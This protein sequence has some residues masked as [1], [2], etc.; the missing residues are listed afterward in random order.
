M[1]VTLRSIY[2]NT[3]TVKNKLQFQFQFKDGSKLW[4]W[5][6]R[7]HVI[8]L[9]KNLFQSVGYFYDF[10]SQNSRLKTDLPGRVDQLFSLPKQSA[11]L[12]SWVISIKT[13]WPL[14][15][16]PEYIDPVCNMV[17]WSWPSEWRF[18]CLLKDRQVFI[19]NWDYL[20][21]FKTS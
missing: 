11:S 1:K 2:M 7:V 9:W 12:V 13:C 20:S 3:E 17:R 10:W 16:S 5:S 6:Q 21:I 8:R 4:S 18:K 15:N 19:M 14:P